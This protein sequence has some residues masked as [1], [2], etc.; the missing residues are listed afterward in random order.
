MALSTSVVCTRWSFGLVLT[1]LAGILL[2]ALSAFLHG[3]YAEARLVGAEGWTRWVVADLLLLAAQ[4][5]FPL[6]T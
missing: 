4:V 5:V 2:T 3:A 6:A 1:V